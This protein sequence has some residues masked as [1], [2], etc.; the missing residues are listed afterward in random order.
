MLVII[1]FEESV[2]VSA[3]SFLFSSMFINSVCLVN[4]NLPSLVM[5]P[6]CEFTSE[7]DLFRCALILVL[8]CLCFYLAT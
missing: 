1:I 8:C 7:L 2:A 3:E 6:V 4:F 5:S